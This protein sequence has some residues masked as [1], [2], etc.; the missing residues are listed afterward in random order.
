MLDRY[1]LKGCGGPQ[2]PRESPDW[3][4][5]LHGVDLS[6]LLQELHEAARQTD[7][8]LPAFT[9]SLADTIYRPFFVAGLVVVLSLGCVWGAIN[10]LIIGLRR[11]FGGV[12]YSW[13]LAHGDALIF[14]FVGLFIMGFACQAFPRFKHTELWR[15]RLAFAALPLMAAGILVQTLAHLLAPPAPFLLLGI[16]GGLLEIAAVVIFAVVIRRTDI[17]RRSRKHMT[18]LFMRR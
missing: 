15:P 1:G 16:C 6:Q 13:I 9:P 11:D 10:L 12:S 4:A 5:G 3:F 14:G 18:A 17:G 7:A 2:G 8:Q